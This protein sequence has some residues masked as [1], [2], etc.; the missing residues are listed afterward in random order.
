MSMF[1][2][3]YPAQSATAVA[4]MIDILSLSML[5]FGVVGIVVTLLL[6]LKPKRAAG[7]SK[8]ATLAHN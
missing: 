3:V 6:V 4:S 8:P 7:K 2:I 5:G 1:T